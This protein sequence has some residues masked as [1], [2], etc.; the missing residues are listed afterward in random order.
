L[1]LQAKRLLLLLNTRQKQ[2]GTGDDQG[3]I[4]AQLTP[5]KIGDNL[6]SDAAI[7]L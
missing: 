1:L 4:L 2:P 5:E 7:V 3:D 6:N